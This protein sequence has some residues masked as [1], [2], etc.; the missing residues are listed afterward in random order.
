MSSDPVLRRDGRD[1][2]F[3]EQDIVPGPDEFPIAFEFQERP[4]AA[5]KHQDMAA[6]VDGY[7]G[8]LN[9]IPRS[10]RA[11]CI[12]ELHRPIRDLLIAQIWSVR[13]Q[14]GGLLGK[15]QTE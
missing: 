9:E 10:G 12:H 8:H 7:A 14:S 1:F 2:S 13:S 15:N 3:T 11:S 6:R 4:G 5:V